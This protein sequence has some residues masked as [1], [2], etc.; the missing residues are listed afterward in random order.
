MQAPDDVARDDVILGFCL[1]AYRYSLKT[2]EQGEQPRLVV[3]ATERKGL[4]AQMARAI[5]FA[6]DL[7]NTPANLLGPSELAR[8]AKTA[9]RPLGAEVEVIKGTALD[10]AYPL[11]AH[12]GNGSQRGPRVVV[13]RWHGTH[14]AKDAPLISLVGKGVCFD[15]GGMTSNPPAACCA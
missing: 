3:T 8:E 1:G 15:S 12:V 6:R 14:A 5:C 10:E 9:L 7:I 13:A 2:E 11:L 4:A